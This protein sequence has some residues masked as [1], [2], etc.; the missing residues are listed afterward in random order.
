LSSVRRYFPAF[1]ERFSRTITAARPI[2][3]QK[4]PE[5]LLSREF[6]VF[7]HGRRDGT[8]G[9]V[10]VTGGKM[11]DFRLMAE[12]TADVVARLL[13]RGSPCRTNLLSLDGKTV[14]DPAFPPPFSPRLKHFLR[15]HPRL[16]ELHALT[17][18][19]VVLGKNLLRRCTTGAP[20]STAED[21]ARHYDR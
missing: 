20:L 19:G 15:N 10:T 6:D 3:G 11:S 12:S 5:K 2:L 9:F 17:H 16:R 13:G 14:K 21:F 1:P 7:D 4:G 8:P 18:L